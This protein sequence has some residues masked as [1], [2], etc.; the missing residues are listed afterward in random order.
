MAKKIVTVYVEED[1]LKE[2]D[3]IA[4]KT[5]RSKSWIVNEMLELMVKEWRRCNYGSIEEIH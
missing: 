3:I 5:K 1:I 2:L 4:D